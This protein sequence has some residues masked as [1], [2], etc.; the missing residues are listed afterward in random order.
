M[1]LIPAITIPPAT[2]D[3]ICTRLGY[4]GD[5]ADNA[6]KLTFVRDYIIRSLKNMAKAQQRDQD[7]AS[8]PLPAD[9]NIT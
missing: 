9:P 6:A 2:A 3:L 7:L 4:A 1:A 5:P 8:V